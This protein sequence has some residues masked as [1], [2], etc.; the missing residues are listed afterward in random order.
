MD[1]DASAVQGWKRCVCVPTLVDVMLTPT[2]HPH[3]GISAV[4][5]QEYHRRFLKF[6]LQDIVDHEHSADYDSPMGSSTV[7]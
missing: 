3:T 2:H 6:I 7:S 5:P 4:Q 1:Q